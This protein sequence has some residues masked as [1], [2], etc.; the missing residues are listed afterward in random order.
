MIPTI[1]R[2]WMPSGRMRHRAGRASVGQAGRRGRCCCPCATAQRSWSTSSPPGRA[3][4]LAWMTHGSSGWRHAGRTLDSGGR[5][6]P[7]LPGWWPRE[8]RGGC[9]CGN[10]AGA[11]LGRVL[12]DAPVV[13]EGGVRSLHL[14]ELRELVRSEQRLELLVE[15]LHHRLQLGA[16]LVHLDD[17]LAHGGGVGVRDRERGLQLG[18]QRLLRLVDRRGLGLEVLEQL[19]GG[20][21]L[22]LGEVQLLRQLLQMHPE[23]RLMRGWGGRRGAGLHGQ[24][25][26]GE[27]DEGGGQRQQA[28]RGEGHVSR[29]SHAVSLCI[30][31]L[32]ATPELHRLCASG[33]YASGLNESEAPELAYNPSDGPDRAPVTPTFAGCVGGPW[34]GGRWPRG[35]RGSRGCSGRGAPRGRPAA[36][37]RRRT[38]WSPA[39]RRGASRC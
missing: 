24:R 5:G 19:L 6:P 23:H 16:V 4:R 34:Q 20:R 21:L 35:S 18:A 22:L 3:G 31:T 37:A 38:A 26:H 13:P 11:L 32:Q 8:G 28:N 15:G 9:D 33:V 25:R 1:L 36:P 29:C 12:D 10:G 14:L 2:P 39:R 27:Q 7:P 17:D 30:Y